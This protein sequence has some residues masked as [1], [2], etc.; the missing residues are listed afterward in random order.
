MPVA[1]SLANGRKDM[2][3]APFHLGRW[4]FAI[5]VWAVIWVIFE[6]VLFSIP[7]VVPVTSIY[8]STSRLNYLSV[9][10]TMLT[11][12]QTMRLWSSLDSPC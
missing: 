7:A 10:L 12:V 8:M 3:G 2:E 5:N 1:L 11:T 9:V 6:I 4:G